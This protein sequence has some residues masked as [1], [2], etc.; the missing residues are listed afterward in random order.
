MHSARTCL[1]VVLVG[2]YVVPSLRTHRNGGA[3][4]HA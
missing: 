2:E 3:K 1:I 4:S